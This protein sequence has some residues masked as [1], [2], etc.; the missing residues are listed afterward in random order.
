MG[1]RKESGK[2]GEKG[3][4]RGRSPRAT[5]SSGPMPANPPPPSSE[6]TSLKVKSN[7]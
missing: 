7:R 1:R 3:R 6:G 4:L 5:R 2:A